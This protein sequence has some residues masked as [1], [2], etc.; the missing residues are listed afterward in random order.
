MDTAASS[1]TADG[2]P[3]A[4]G[5]AHE[6]NLDLAGRG[7]SLTA[8]RSRATTRRATSVLPDFST[9]RTSPAHATMMQKVDQMAADL[10]TA[11]LISD[12]LVNEPFR[13]RLAALRRPRRGGVPRLRTQL[14]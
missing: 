3:G 10:L 2:G 6:G 5:S 11:G 8:G 12:P 4:G 9:T 7:G 14:A 1:A 13:T